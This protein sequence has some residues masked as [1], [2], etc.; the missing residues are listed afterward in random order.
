MEPHIP[1]GTEVFPHVRVVLGMVIGLGVTRLLSGFARIVQHPG[2]TPVYG[3]H[4]GWV[5][6]LLLTLVHFWWWQFGLFGLAH[7]T[8]EVYFFVITYA[9]VLFLLCALLFPDQMSD[10]AGYEDF[11]YARR[12]WFFGFLA[13][14]YLLDLVDTLIKGEA[15]Y[16]RFGMEY[17]IR[18]PLF[19]ALSLIAMWTENRRYHLAFVAFALIYQIVWILRLFDRIG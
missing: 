17:L 6:L 10:Y 7:W 16:A 5:A 9:I 2:Q 1:S 14:T 8:F 3:V 13:A 19:V 11:F 15:H 12:R 4:L 18:T